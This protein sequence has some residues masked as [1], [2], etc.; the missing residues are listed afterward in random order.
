ME[1]VVSGIKRSLIRAMT[2]GETLREPLMAFLNAR[3]STLGGGSLIK[4]GIFIVY[5]LK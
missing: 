4:H 2:D 1:S 5:F 3:D